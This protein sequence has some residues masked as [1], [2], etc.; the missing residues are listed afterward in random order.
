M[1][2]KKK[3]ETSLP[4]S[5][6]FQFLLRSGQSLNPANT[7]PIHP[8][9]FQKYLHSGPFPPLLSPL[10]NAALSLSSALLAPRRG[11]PLIGG[12]REREREGFRI[13]TSREAKR[14]R[15]RGREASIREIWPR[16]LSSFEIFSQVVSISNCVQESETSMS[17]R[18]AVL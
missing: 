16:F 8:L 5:Y 10:I 11:T 4:Q 3:K 2:G 1:E 14:E 18:L 9:P 12:E 13:S 7:F 17:A 6:A 15:E